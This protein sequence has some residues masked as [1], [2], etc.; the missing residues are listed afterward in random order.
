[1]PISFNSDGVTTGPITVPF[2]ISLEMKLTSVIGGKSFIGVALFLQG[3]HVGFLL[4][5]ASIGEH[6]TTGF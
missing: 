2:T 1:V 5:G 4:T 6:I 3:V